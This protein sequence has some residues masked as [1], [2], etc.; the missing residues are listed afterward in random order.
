[1]LI[2]V[3]K[4]LHGIH[5]TK[6][7]GCTFFTRF[8]LG[9]NSKKIVPQSFRI[10]YKQEYF[11]K[12]EMRFLLGTAVL[13]MANGAYSAESITW[14]PVCVNNGHTLVA[15][16]DHFEICKKANFDDG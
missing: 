16:S 14:K 13:L 8:Q 6:C 10:Y 1:M 15:S 2:R 11:M 9:E 7:D 12:K 5:F 4:G 3:D